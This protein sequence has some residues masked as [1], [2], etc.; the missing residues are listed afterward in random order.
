MSTGC[1]MKFSVRQITFTAVF[2]ALNVLLSMF[3]VPTPFGGHFYLTDI[4]VC[5]AGIT[6]NPVLAVVAGGGGAFLGDLFFY[7]AAMLTTLITR[8]V[9]AFVISVFSNYI[10]KKKEIL[11]SVIGC[12]IG[13]IIMVTGYTLGSAFIYSTPEYAVYKIPFQLLQAV[14]G[15]AVAI[16]VAYHLK[17]KK[18]CN[19]YIRKDV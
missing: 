2:T 19:D 14:V 5:L 1:V 8:S 9:Q 15:V 18:I 11:F 6:L 4:A 3:S 16:P 17:I 10:G 13:V 12:A 7:P